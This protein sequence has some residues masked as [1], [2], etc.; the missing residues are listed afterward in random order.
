MSVALF[1]V[2]LYSLNSIFCTSPR[3][4]TIA[5]VREEWLI[6]RRELLCNGLLEDTVFDCWN[7]KLSYSTIW[8]RISTLLHCI[9]C[10]LSFIYLCDNCLLILLLGMLRFHQRLFCQ[11]LGAPLFAF[12]LLKALFRLSLYSI[13]SKEFRLCTVPFFP[14][15]IK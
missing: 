7:T 14:Y 13:F 11:S 4:V 10:V 6:N 15:R 9:G 1:C 5:F 3:A 8:F 2:F 12:T